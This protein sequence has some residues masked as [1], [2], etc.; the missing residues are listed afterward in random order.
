MDQQ[1]LC[2]Q[3]KDSF[4][5]ILDTVKELQQEVNHIENL[6]TYRILVHID[7]LSN[8]DADIESIKRNHRL[9]ISLVEGLEPA[10]TVHLERLTEALEQNRHILPQ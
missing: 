6:L 5:E 3:L 9:L 4:L 10:T 2:E 8:T 7:S 1:T